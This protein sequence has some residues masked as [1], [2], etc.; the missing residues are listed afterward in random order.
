[1]YDRNQRL[2]ILH[3]ISIQEFERLGAK[4][5]LVDI[6]DQTLHDGSKLPLPPIL[7]GTHGNDPKKK[8]LLVYGHLDVQP[9]KKV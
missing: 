6:G 9:A 2:I 7:L 8:N 5:E 1:M 4:T 3:V